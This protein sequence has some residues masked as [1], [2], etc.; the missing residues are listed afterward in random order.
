MGVLQIG[1]TPGA[2]TFAADAETAVAVPL[3]L[4]RHAAIRNE[5]RK[6]AQSKTAAVCLKNP[7]FPDF[8]LLPRIIK[9]V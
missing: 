7:D 1:N 4:C 5:N 6:L 9:F 8:M 2:L 3:P